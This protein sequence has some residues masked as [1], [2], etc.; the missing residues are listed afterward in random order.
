[1]NDTEQFE[2]TE[3]VTELTDDELADLKTRFYRFC[4][5]QKI[6]HKYVQPFM[7]TVRRHQ[8]RLGETR[9]EARRI[10]WE[11]A[12][13]AFT[14]QTL[15][16][17]QQLSDVALAEPPN[18][19]TTQGTAWRLAY[20]GLSLA[21]KQTPELRKQGEQLLDHTHRRIDN[22]LYEKGSRENYAADLDRSIEAFRNG[23]LTCESEVDQIISRLESIRPDETDN[24]L[25]EELRLFISMIY[26]TRETVS[27][28][29]AN[30]W[31]PL[32]AADPQSD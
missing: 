3:D 20:L 4:I 8:R 32:L 26:E 16:T 25:Q 7:T 28:L 10:A 1:M 11:Q 5:Q 9:R 30:R 15:E 21:A 27:Q 23:T 2:S 12:A 22:G 6:W 18:L 29:V 24:G 17:S 19:S 14:V 31:S 13:R